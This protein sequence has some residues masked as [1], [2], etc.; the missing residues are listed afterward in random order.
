V[1]AAQL[2]DAHSQFVEQNDD[3]TRDMAEWF[4]EF[5]PCFCLGL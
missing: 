3:R 1:V 4:D 5:R 2:A